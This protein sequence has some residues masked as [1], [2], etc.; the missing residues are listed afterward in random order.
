MVK[1]STST[2]PIAKRIET[3]KIDTNAVRLPYSEH[4][5]VDQKLNSYVI[6]DYD[7]NLFKFSAFYSKIIL[8]NL[9]LHKQKQ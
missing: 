3:K 8:S 9:F 6:Y 5:V 4:F 2:L 7:S 1:L